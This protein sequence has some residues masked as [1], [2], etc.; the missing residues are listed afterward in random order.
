MKILLMILT[1]AILAILAAVVKLWPHSLAFAA[2]WG[3]ILI[4]LVL[5]AIW[6]TQ[7]IMR[8]HRRVSPFDVDLK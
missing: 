3:I 5:A 8:D 6:V 7:E 1:F 2:H 4:L